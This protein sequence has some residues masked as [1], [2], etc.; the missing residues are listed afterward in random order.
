M[1]KFVARMNAKAKEVGMKQSHF[2]N[3][4]GLSDKHQF[5]TARDIF[6]LS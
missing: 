6:I 1:D 2:V 4:H 5:S 3:P